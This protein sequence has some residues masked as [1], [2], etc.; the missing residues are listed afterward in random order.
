MDGAGG[1]GEQRGLSV[2]GALRSAAWAGIIPTLAW[3]AQSLVPTDSQAA[4]PATSRP[5]G[6]VTATPWAS[7]RR[8]LQ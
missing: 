3:R 7:Q 5:L 2:R 1:A 6:V 4:S 8:L